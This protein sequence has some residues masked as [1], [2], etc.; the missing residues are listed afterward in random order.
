MSRIAVV[1]IVTAAL[2]VGC[3]SDPVQSVNASADAPVASAQISSAVPGYLVYRATRTTHTVTEPEMRQAARAVRGDTLGRVYYMGRKGGFDHFFV[4]GNVLTE[5][6]RVRV[7][8]GIT[9]APVPYV[10][11]TEQWVRCGPFAKDG[12]LP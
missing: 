1:G 10:K 6:Y 9:K 11:D 5:T 7:P 8:N 2:A 3:A 12:W 4:G